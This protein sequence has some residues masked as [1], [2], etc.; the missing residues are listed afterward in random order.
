VTY[1]SPLLITIR[2]TSDGLYAWHLFDGPDGAFHESGRAPTI[3]RCIT[4]IARARLDIANH[5]TSNSDPNAVRQPNLPLDPAPIPQVHPP[6][7]HPLPAQQDI[8]AGTH[9]QESSATFYL[10]PTKSG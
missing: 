6:E 7:G 9:P 5:I 3:D 10:R 8:P 1:L 4:E 2:S